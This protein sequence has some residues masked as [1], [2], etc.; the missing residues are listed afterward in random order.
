MANPKSKTQKKL[1][2]AITLALTEVCE[3]LLKQVLGFQWLTHQADYARFPGSLMVT[4]VFDTEAHR[5]AQ[6]D[7]AAMRSL[8]QAALLKIGV[9]LPAVVKQVVFD[10]EEA[11]T[12]QCEGDWQR[13]LAWQILKPAARFH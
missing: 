6:A 2:H 1:D 7:S 11:C 8:I 5:Q 4:C 10:S 3:S 13:R 12:Q 9:T